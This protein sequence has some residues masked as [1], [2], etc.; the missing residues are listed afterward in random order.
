MWEC[1][2]SDFSCPRHEWSH[3]TSKVYG[4]T[5]DNNCGRA[6]R[7]ASPH[8]MITMAAGLLALGFAFGNIDRR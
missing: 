6:G 5:Y 4:M 1:D 7:G 3:G 8:V 2:L